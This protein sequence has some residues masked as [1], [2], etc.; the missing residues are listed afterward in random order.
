[1][2]G[3]KSAECNRK[4]CYIGAHHRQNNVVQAVFYMYI[5][6]WKTIPNGFVAPLRVSF[7][8][9]ILPLARDQE[10]KHA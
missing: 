1:M 10:I 8:R 9:L 4:K 5:P 3:V 2:T 6:E 7:S